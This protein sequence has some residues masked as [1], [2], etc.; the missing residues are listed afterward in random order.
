MRLSLH[1]IVIARRLHCLGV[2]RTFRRVRPV[3][4]FA[5]F[6]SLLTSDLNP[7][8]SPAPNFA[9]SCSN[10]NT[11]LSNQDRGRGLLTPCAA[12]S[13]DGRGDVIGD[14]VQHGRS[15]YYAGIGGDSDSRLWRLTEGA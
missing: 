15:R 14:E 1:V 4:N 13:A 5:A 8:G 9:R 3:L 11:G 10:T 2:R 6:L 7:S 12:V